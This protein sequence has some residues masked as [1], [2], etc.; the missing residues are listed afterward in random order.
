[1]Q[2]LRNLGRAYIPASAPV[3]QRSE[4]PLRS[5]ASP[6][7]SVLRPSLK[8]RQSAAVGMRLAKAA[9]DS[10]LADFIPADTSRDT[11]SLLFRAH[12]GR[13]PRPDLLPPTQIN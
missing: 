12:R 9:V 11:D 1:V 6:P 7:A 5:A 3:E 2:L 8:P 10:V 4:A 13:R